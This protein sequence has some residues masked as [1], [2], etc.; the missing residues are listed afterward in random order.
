MASVEAC[1]KICSEIPDCKSITF[2]DD[3]ELCWIK[4]M[5]FT[6]DMPDYKPNHK[7]VTG[8]LNM[9]CMSVS[10]KPEKQE[11]SSFNTFIFNLLKMKANIV[12]ALYWLWRYLNMLQ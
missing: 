1:V 4:Y 10:G 9:N 2:K 12:I 3:E 7:D 11:L 5:S 6:P 8:S